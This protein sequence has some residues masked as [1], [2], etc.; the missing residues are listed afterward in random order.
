MI[1]AP[2][3]IS[4][5]WFNP[6]SYAQYTAMDWWSFCKTVLINPPMPTAF[7]AY[8]STEELPTIDLLSVMVL[9]MNNSD[10]KSGGI[11]TRSQRMNHIP[12]DIP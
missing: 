11:W 5:L 1:D 10:G 12:P 3:A 2:A 8:I 9:F 6:M 7:L 4:T